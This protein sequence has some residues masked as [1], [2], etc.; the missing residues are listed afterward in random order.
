MTTELELQVFIAKFEGQDMSIDIFDIMR[1]NMY[2]TGDSAA[3]GILICPLMRKHAY[4]L[5]YVRD[6]NGNARLD[7]VQDLS[8][9][10]RMIRQQ[11][12]GWV[13]SSIWLAKITKPEIG[14]G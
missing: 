5:E 8:V 9:C 11:I 3:L 14:E 13:K 2:I 6:N 7:M 10:L 1:H 12:S 4:A